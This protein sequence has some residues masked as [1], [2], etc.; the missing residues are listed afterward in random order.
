VSNLTLT[1]EQAIKD[2]EKLADNLADISHQIKSPVTSILLT[3]QLL[4]QD[5]N[6]N[7]LNQ[8]R[9]HTKHLEHL[10]QTLLTLSRLDAG[11]LVFE[12]EPVDVYTMLQLTVETLEAAI[13][14]KNI[15]VILPNHTQ[16]NYMGDMDW[17][18]EAMLNLLN[19]SIEHTPRGGLIEF[20]YCQNPLYTEIDLIDNGCGFEERD[21]PHLF[22]RFYRGANTSESGT[23]IGLSLAKSIIERQKGFLNAKNLTDGGA[24]FQVRF[25]SH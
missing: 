21:L 7:Y 13:N 22:E 15:T 19:N 18:L 20:S 23:G 11:V 8:I 25:Y 14:I 16:I 10:T 17:S 6:L 4:E 12:H 2:R 3:T 1:R 9:R 24:C 5:S